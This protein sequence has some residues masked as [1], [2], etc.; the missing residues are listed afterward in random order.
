ML[1]RLDLPD[2]QWAD[3]LVRP[4]HAEYVA[5]KRVAEGDSE[6]DWQLEM[7]RQFTKDWLVRDEDGKEASLK[8][9]SKIDP[10]ITDA[11]FQEALNRWL[12]WSVRRIPLVK[13]RLTLP[14]SSE[15]SESSSD[16]TSTE[17]PST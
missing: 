13:A 4:R 11:I 10:D 16:D 8:D 5:I 9:W 12:E 15:T 7:A 1:E 14:S 3:L 2:G 6:V 17:A